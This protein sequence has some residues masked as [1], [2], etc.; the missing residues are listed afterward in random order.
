MFQVPVWAWYNQCCALGDLSTI[1]S[2]TTVYD[3]FTLEF[4]C[5]QF[6]S[7]DVMWSLRQRTAGTLEAPVHVTLTDC[8]VMHELM[9]IQVNLSCP[10]LSWRH[11]TRTQLRYFGVFPSLPSHIHSY[12]VSKNPVCCWDVLHLIFC[13]LISGLITFPT[14]DSALQSE[15]WQHRR[16]LYY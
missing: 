3:Y 14:S 8:I 4:L 6:A 10:P 9:S 2:V 12:L 13:E 16:I 1:H 11:Q 7:L 5:P 15:Q